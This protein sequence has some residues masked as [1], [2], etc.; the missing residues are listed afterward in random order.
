LIF[1][2]ISILHMGV[3]SGGLFCF[4]EDGTINIEKASGLGT[5][6]DKVVVLPHTGGLDIQLYSSNTC[7]P[8]LDVSI[9]ALSEQLLQLKAPSI[10]DPSYLLA[11]TLPLAPSLNERL[12]ASLHS[13][14]EAPTASTSEYQPRTTV[15]LI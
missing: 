15:L 11:R 6:D 10:S 5:C 8:C 1:S 14:N 13:S 7:P 12:R 2:L 9:Q 4:E 3:I